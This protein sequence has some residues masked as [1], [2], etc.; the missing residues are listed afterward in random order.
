[1]STFTR[2]HL[3]PSAAGAAILLLSLVWPG[4]AEAQ[5]R[6]QS[7]V[8]TTG[9][10]RLTGEIKD[11]SQ[12]RLSLDMRAAGIVSIKWEQVAEL[13]N[14]SLLVV[15]TKDGSRLV[16]TLE[17]AGPGA[18]VVTGD[19]GRTVLDLASIVGLVPIRHSFLRR[20]DGSINVGSSYTQSSG[21]AQLSAT[22]TVTA[23]RPSFEW[24]ASADEYVTV[25]SDG[26]TS[27]RFTT[28]FAYSRYLPHNLA[29]FGGGQIER[30]EDLGFSLR[31][32]LG[33]GLERTLLRSNRTT[34]VIGAGLGA[35]REMPVDGDTDTPFPALLT[36]RY[37]FFTYST[38]KTSLET[39][40]TALPILN[41]VGRWRL[42]ANASVSRELF[43]D[44]SVA[45]T[46]YESF[47]NR[48]PTVEADRND[49]GVTLSLGF[50]F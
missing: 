28:T 25:D 18:V 4:P 38:P 12:G 2:R 37:S 26:V 35:S 50:V 1:V 24:R 47:D 31:A 22:F 41:Q 15:E 46:V 10:D 17:P 21:V 45:F 39:D 11:L 49:A 43:K 6:P 19:T 8:V 29:L 20:L 42:E 30:N 36:F 5:P 9:G 3:H 44:F 16:G 13:T 14:P 23:H 7:V 34:L 32:T 27:E 33:G 48:P 40:F